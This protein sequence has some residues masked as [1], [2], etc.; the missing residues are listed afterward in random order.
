MS[1]LDG[2]GLT[3]DITPTL[4]LM[5]WPT[6]I[7]AVVGRS[8]SIVISAIVHWFL[9]LAPIL[10]ANAIPP[11]Q[12]MIETQLDLCL[13]IHWHGVKVFA[14]YLSKGASALMDPFI[15][16]DLLTSGRRIC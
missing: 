14:S 13:R 7:A 3:L 4:I 2:L 15:T 12:T 9:D 11:W 6:A 16:V 1:C 8:A 10:G 5:A